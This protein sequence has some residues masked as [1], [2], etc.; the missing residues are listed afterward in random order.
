MPT[1]VGMFI[2]TWYSGYIVDQHKIT[3]DTHDWF[4]IWKVP[5]MIALGVLVYFILFFREKKEMPAA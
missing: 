3:A 1:R 5:A 4:S 2:G